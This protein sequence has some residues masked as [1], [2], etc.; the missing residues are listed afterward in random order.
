MGDIIGIDIGLRLK[1][2]CGDACVTYAVGA[3]APK[4]QRLL[5]VTQE[6]LGRGDC[7]A[8][9]PQHFL[10]DIGTAIH[11]YVDSQGMTVV[12]E[13]GG[14]GIGRSLHEAP[15][16][17][18]IRMH[19]PGPRLRPDMVFTI[20]PMVNLGKHNWQVLEDGWTVVTK[21]GSLSAQFEHTIAI[22]ADGPEIL[23]LA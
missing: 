10:H 11:D 5:D 19:D 22:T 7:R 23:T 17:S 14:H 3:I 20:E 1:G 6:A 9:Q 12:R 8:S 16:V 15:S 21:D 13:W 4:A 18:H 2:Y